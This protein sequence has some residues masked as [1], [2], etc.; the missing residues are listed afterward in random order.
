M[1]SMSFGKSG[2]ILCLIGSITSA[3]SFDKFECI[4]FFIEMIF[5]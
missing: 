2:G 1:L 5:L 4:Q 3:F